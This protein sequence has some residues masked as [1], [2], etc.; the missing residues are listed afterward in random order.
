MYPGHVAAAVAM[1]H[2][3]GDS[4]TYKGKRYTVTDPTYVN[5][6]AGMTMPADRGKKPQVIGL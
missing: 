2:A 5:A 1:Q 6:N 3:Q 4:H